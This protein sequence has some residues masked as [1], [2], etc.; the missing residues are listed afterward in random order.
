MEEGL[1]VSEP[2]HGIII[3]DIM[4]R[5]QIPQLLEFLVIRQVERCPFKPREERIWLLG[6]F[7]RIDLLDRSI[8]LDRGLFVKPRHRLRIPEFIRGHFLLI[9]PT[10]RELREQVRDAHLLQRL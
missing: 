3:F 1:R 9:L 5:Q 7:Y 6:H 2:E 4:V 10:G 8:L